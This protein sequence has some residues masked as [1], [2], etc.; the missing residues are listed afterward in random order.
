MLSEQEIQ[1]HEFLK[2]SLNSFSLKKY[3]R[4]AEVVLVEKEGTDV[5]IH[6]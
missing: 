2:S 4:V 6:I 3:L 5:G 1:L